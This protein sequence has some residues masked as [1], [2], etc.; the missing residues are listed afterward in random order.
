MRSGVG[1]K[2]ADAIDQKVADAMDSNLA[3]GFGKSVRAVGNAQ[4]PVLKFRF[5]SYTYKVLH[6]PRV[7]S[8]KNV[9]KGLIFCEK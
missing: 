8:T 7:E 9:N 3:G 6:Y 1:K 4:S 2:P 5:P